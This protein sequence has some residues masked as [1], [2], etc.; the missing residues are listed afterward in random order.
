MD[1]V[2]SQSKAGKRGDES[3]WTKGHGEQSGSG[4][5]DQ[6]SFE[7]SGQVLPGNRS[8]LAAPLLSL[9]SVAIITP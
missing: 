6:F 4:L 9:T 7:T 8:K 5:L 1:F 2:E 3:S